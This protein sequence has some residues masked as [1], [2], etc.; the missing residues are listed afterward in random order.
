MTTHKKNNFDART[1]FIFLDDNHWACWK[2]GKCHANCGHHIF[3]RGQAEGCEK[4]A[5]NYAPLN[6]HECHLPVHGW[7]TSDAG[8]KEMFEKTLEYLSSMEY[9]L[10]ELD[11]EFLEKY[12]MDIYK[13]RIKI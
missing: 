12:K 9:T 11:N 10:T 1:H 4:S 3:G 7:L 2:C 6:N 8:K 13:L 5:L